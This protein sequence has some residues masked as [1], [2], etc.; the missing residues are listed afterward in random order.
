MHTVCFQSFK[1]RIAYFD[2][3]IELID[4]LRDAML[5][6]DLVEDGSKFVLKGLDPKSHPHLSRRKNSKGSR[7]LLA[8]HIRKTVYSGYVKDVYE[9]VT[10]YL[11]KIIKLASEKGLN[12]SRFIGEHGFKVDAKNLLELGGWDKVLSMVTDTVFQALESEKSTLKL[13]EKTANK[14]ALDVER[15]LIIAAQ[16]YLEVRHF[17]VHSDGKVTEEFKAAHPHIKL[18]RD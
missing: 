5:G 6:D 4:I 17:L 12:S 7:E 16:P 18:S 11:R 1:T 14:L 15:N 9:E 3:D 13:L 2:D 10:E 8:N